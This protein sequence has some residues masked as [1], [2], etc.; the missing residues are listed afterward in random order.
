VRNRRADLLLAGLL[1]AASYIPLLLTRTGDVAADTKQYLYLD[2]AKLTSGAAYMWD[3]NVGLGTVT[4]QNIGYL[5]PM[6]PYY[7]AV[8]WLGIPVWIGQRI[9]MGSLLF[10]AG[11]GVA[12]C[13]RYLGLEGPGRA[14][15]ALAYMLSPYTIDYLDRI[16]AILMPWAALGWLVGLTVAAVR[17]GRW[18]YPALFA[19]VVALVGGVN[20]TSIL[21][22]LVA[23]LLLLAYMVWATREVEWRRAA[24][25]ASRIAGLCVAVSLWWV[26]G[27]WA[28]GRYGVNVLRVTETVPTVARTSSAP[29]VLRGLGYWYFY[30]WDKVQPWTVPAVQ[31]TQSPWLLGLSLSLPGLSILL[32]S[33]TRWRYRGLALCLVAVGTV[34]AV[35]VFPFAH[36]SLFGSLLK[37]ASNGSTIALAMRSVDR[38]VPLVVLGLALLM[39]SGV[40]A[41]RLRF[42]VAGIAAGAACVALVAADLPAL[43]SGGMIASN[44]SRPSTVPA[45]WTAAASYLNGLGSASRVLGLPGEDFANYAW[46]VTEDP[47]APGLLSRPYVARQVVPSGSPAAADLLQSLDEPIQEGTLD[48]SALA[49]IARLMSVGQVLLQSD[50]Q[51]ERYHLPLPQAL[52]QEFVPAPQGLSGP[53]PFGPPNPAPMIRYPLDSEIRLGLPADEAE[54]PALAVFDV[55][56][57]RSLVRAESASRPMV[58]SGDGTGLVEAASANLLSGDPTIFY[59]A[60]FAANPA[61]LAQELQADPTLVVTDTNPLASYRWG[62]LRDNVG[63]VEQPGV[64][65]PSTGPSDYTLPVF[66]G[67]TTASNTVAVLSGVASVQANAYGDS[68]AY[69]PENRP[70][71]AVD[72]DISTAWTFGAYSPVEGRYIRINLVHPVTT[73]HVTLTQAQLEQ[74]DRRIDKVTLLFDGQDPVTVALDHSSFQAPGQTVSF[75]GRTFQQ[76]EVRVDSAGRVAGKRYDGLAP[77]GFAEIGIPGVSDASEAL[78]LPVDL[79]SAAGTASIADPL[80]ILM[81]RSRVVEPPRHDPESVLS[82]IFE[83]PTART[84]SLAGTA[85]ISAGDS[86]N[87]IDELIGLTPPPAAALGQSSGAAVVVAANSSTRLDEDRQARANDALDGNSRTAWIAETG[88]QAGEWLSFTLSRPVT[89]GHLALQVV[90][91]G[92]HSLPTLLTI[93]TEDG[94][95]TVPVPEPPVGYG[96]PQGSTSTVAVDFPALSGRDVRVTVDSVEQVRALDYYSTFA[97]IKDILPVGIAELGIPG[98]AQPPA[99]ARLPYSCRSDL[100]RIDD[101]PVSVAVIGT[102]ADALAGRP[103][104]LV[105]CG[106]SSSG[107]HLGPGEHTVQTSAGQPSGLSIDQLWLGSA[108]GGGELAF[109]GGAGASAALSDAVGAAAAQPPAVTIDH[110]GRT[111]WKV[112]VDGN[113][114]P[115]WLVLGQS[116][117][118]GW[119]ATVAG[120]HSLGSPGLIDGYANGWFVP[121]GIVRGPTVINIQWTPQRVVWAAITVS[122]AA[123]L[124]CLLLAAWPSVTT[125]VSRRRGRRGRR[126]VPRAALV[127]SGPGPVSWEAFA[128]T[129]PKAR[130]G[131]LR[132]A[133][134]ALG[135]AGASAVVSRP[136]IGVVGGAAVAAGCLWSR[137]RLA[138]RVA[139]L[140]ALAAIPAYAVEQQVVHRY[141]PTIDWPAALSSANDIAWLA[142]VLV[143]ADLVAGLRRQVRGA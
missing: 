127:G 87:L 41:I 123:L 62:S 138:V 120:G 90:N 130:C 73:D 77:V 140:I 125:L 46:G 50:L 107:L 83:L 10:L 28:E 82:R 36:P 142:L 109:A 11:L 3:P 69:T 44:L 29:E 81:Q 8:H 108:A 132:A 105:G 121:A 85:E 98:V 134:L 25:A 101:Q 55:S 89:F 128:R 66:P 72:G 110:Q 92:R 17:T 79:L 13:A 67:A 141:L 71:N 93:T 97:Q 21:L 115:F 64:P 131:L 118:K 12:Y 88:P 24:S 95:R 94:S 37:D 45:Y 119:S 58:V 80:L 126:P 35:G 48:P 40:T 54:P 111:S 47:V 65:D 106:S 59:T 129:K 53:T 60:S 91:D 135:W 4:H 49:P 100:L 112:T 76:L 99:P 22:V 31:Y 70:V 18:R 19:L 136:L 39:G 75:P 102:T 32:G 57:P 33:L 27:L 43:W 52:W 2:P 30:G 116:F 124:V 86:D 61:G 84:F 103:L 42:P 15:A 63:Q 117:S 113:G 114:G 6:G 26:A 7:S 5:F 104:S 133:I 14:V 122:G 96:R 139:A 9:W 143:G 38:I 56:D 23:P 51:Y 137:G 74:P 16:S 1:A 78:R 68:L 34:V 20:A